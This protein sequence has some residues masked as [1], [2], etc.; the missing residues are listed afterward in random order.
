M[1]P[2]TDD[3]EWTR[4]PIEIHWV[5]EDFRWLDAHEDKPRC[6]FR[7]TSV[8]SQ[9]ATVPTRYLLAYDGDDMLPMW[10]GM[11][12]ISIP[13]TDPVPP[14]SDLPPWTAGSDFVWSNV[15]G[16]IADAL[17]DDSTDFPRLEGYL[18]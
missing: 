7:L 10:Q 14:V 6:R 17:R 2:R 9:Y 11:S 12:F 13:G 3:D 16:P 15:I 4:K 5:G 1:A 8:P 18:P